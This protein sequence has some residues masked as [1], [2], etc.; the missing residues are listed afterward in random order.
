MCRG[1]GGLGA[2][3]PQTPAC[4]NS[5]ASAYVA[6]L[7]ITL[8]SSTNLCLVSA[9]PWPVFPL[10]EMH[11]DLF[12]RSLVQLSVKPHPQFSAP[13]FA[14]A[15]TSNKWHHIGRR[16][17]CDRSQQVKAPAYSST[18]ARREQAQVQQTNIDPLHFVFMAIH[19]RETAK[20]CHECFRCQTI[21]KTCLCCL[22][23]LIHRRCLSPIQFHTLSVSAFLSHAKHTATSSLKT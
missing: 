16:E 9:F 21:N 6:S 20:T 22:Y 2:T 11:T 7:V 19:L 4:K 23:V 17:G 18:H 13:C 10:V 15:E 3:S 12:R 8:S 5:A 14:S 1:G